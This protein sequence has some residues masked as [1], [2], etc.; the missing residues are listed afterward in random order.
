VNDTI[1]TVSYNNSFVTGTNISV[2]ASGCVPSAARTLQVLRVAPSTALGLISGP[3]NA[4][5]SL[6]SATNPSGIP[7]TYMI[8][9]SPIASSYTWTAPTGATITA[10]PDG[11]GINDTTIQVTYSAGFSSGAVTVYITN[12]CGS[13]PVR[14]LS[15]ARLSVGAASNIDIIQTG[16]CP[17]R[18]YT[19]TLAGMP[20]NATSVLWAVPPAGTLVS[21]QG[22][23]SITVSYPST[24]V[25]G[26]ITATPY[27]NCSNAATRTVTI[28]L[29]SCPEPRMAQ[30][31]TT[32][33]IPSVEPVLQVNVFPNPSVSNFKMRVISS[34]V[35]KIQ[36]RMLDLSGREIIRMNIQPYE[37]VSLGNNLKAGAYMIEVRQGKYIKTTRVTKF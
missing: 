7:V 14:S 20:A 32:A 29:P 36:V 4:C 12:S 31:K 24:A 3:T 16:T 15:V 11:T 26:N 2:Q 6:V 21:G 17:F 22:T 1:I 8:R 34:S 10:H 35:E 28:K 18:V 37:T 25:S 19:Y 33:A 5:P 30:A 13:S 27:N 23:T 9:K